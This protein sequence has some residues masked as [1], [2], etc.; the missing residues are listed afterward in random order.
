VPHLLVVAMILE[1]HIVSLRQTTIQQQHEQPLIVQFIS[2]YNP[3]LI[4]DDQTNAEMTTTSSDDLAV[5]DIIVAMPPEQEGEFKTEQVVKFLQHCQKSVMSI[6]SGLISNAMSLGGAGSTVPLWKSILSTV[7]ESILY[8]ASS[9]R[10]TR[11]NHEMKNDDDSIIQAVDNNVKDVIDNTKSVDQDDAIWNGDTNVAATDLLCRL[12]SVV[13]SKAMQRERHWDVWGYELCSALSRV[14][15]LIEER[16]ILEKPQTVSDGSAYVYKEDQIRL[17][18]SIIDILIYGRNNA[19]WCQLAL[20]SMS[21]PEQGGGKGPKRE[22]TSNSKLL[23]PILNPCL[24]I[25][26]ASIHC[27]P[28]YAK[29][30]VIDS[31][32]SLNITDCTKETVPPE[33][34]LFA[35]VIA[36]LDQTLT[37]AIV[38]LSF[39]NAREIA[40]TAMATCRTFIRERQNISEDD[41]FVGL[42][43][44]LF[45]KLAE[46]LRV[47]YQ[48]ERRLRDNALFDAYEDDGS[49]SAQE[50]AHG[51]LAIER[52]I[53]GAESI[54]DKSI[55]E[56]IE[57]IT[58]GETER[59]PPRKKNGQDDFV[60]FHEHSP[61]S[62]EAKG[63]L[64]FKRLQGLGST[65]EEWHASLSSELGEDER[66]CLALH[67]LQP[68]LDACD[69][70]LSQDANDTEVVKLFDTGSQSSDRQMQLPMVGSQTAADAMSVF[71]EFAAAEKSRL[72]EILLR[73]LPSHRY[74]RMS[75]SERFCWARYTELTPHTV[76]QIWE[77]SMPDGNRDVRSRICTTPCIS[78]FRRYLPKHLDLEAEIEPE[79]T[80]EAA[81]EEKV[82]D[83]AFSP[84]RA[85]SVEDID[86]FTK[87]LLKAGNLAIVDI[88]KKENYDED[89]LPDPF[90]VPAD[91]I[92]DEDEAEL[93]TESEIASEAPVQGTKIDSGALEENAHEDLDSGSEDLNV[94]DPNLHSDLSN[95]TTDFVG[96]GHHSITTSSFS[97]PPDNSSSSL[98]L[99]HS[100]AAGMI[101]QHFDHCLHVKAEGSRHCSMLLTQSHLIL[102]YDI[103]QEGFFE[104]EL[105]AKQEEAD[106]QRMADDVGAQKDRDPESL[107][108]FKDEKRKKEEAALR[109]KSIRW[110]LSEVSHV[111][112]RR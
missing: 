38:G 8:S 46:E 74:S 66:F 75:F 101:E 72:K 7:D 51:S 81:C 6:A 39:L 40:L 78:Q 79:T 24:R 53:L 37:A 108:E 49:N 29:I 99:M 2:E 43:K 22:M 28:R 16:S 11:K 42:C 33:E 50:A 45:A 85:S 105:L 25:L 97:T 107:K 20:P 31:G 106:R 80:Q 69:E 84:R 34:S 70:V 56:S 55:N 26:L 10:G 59:S 91:G 52:L 88:T 36:E 32:E 73:F 44:S 100:A 17:I 64:G 98:S 58:F 102:E 76:Q 111:Y 94:S 93:F 96:K 110:N 65:L 82:A 47:R 71:F 5:N 92:G 83:A 13:M 68:Y 67:F 54:F 112:L 109:P 86:A 60:L 35:R 104:G 48:S 63:I 3:R 19:G 14:C 61:A 57:E 12:L 9:A 18:C 4:A 23:L 21:P 27:I 30:A 15:F 41:A 77:R 90:A 62:Q 103:N 95:V 89:D 1:N 87:S